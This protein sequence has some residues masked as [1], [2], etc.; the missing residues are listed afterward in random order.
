MFSGSKMNF[1]YFVP[2]YNMVGGRSCRTRQGLLFLVYRGLKGW[3]VKGTNRGP[4]YGMLV[5]GTFGREVGPIRRQKEEVANAFRY[6][7]P[8]FQSPARELVP[9]KM[10]CFIVYG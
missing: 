5:L 2:T 6:S 8:T 10:W 4:V 1:R 9:L 3:S 7:F